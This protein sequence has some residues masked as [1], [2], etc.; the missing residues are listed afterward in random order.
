MPWEIGEM[1]PEQI[2]KH[3]RPLKNEKDLRN[4]NPF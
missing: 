3:G 4:Y 1:T 2:K